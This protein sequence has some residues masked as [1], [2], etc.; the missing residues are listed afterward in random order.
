MANKIVIFTPMYNNIYSGVGTYARALVEGLKERNYDISVV[1]PDC[2][3]DSPSFIKLKNNKMDPSPNKWISNSM[4]YNSFLKNPPFKI[5]IAH[6]VNAQELLFVKKLK[7]IKFVATVHDSYSFDLKYKKL[8]KENF[9]DWRSRYIYYNLLFKLERFAFKKADMII[10]NT[11]FVKERL[12]DFY[13]IDRD[14]VLTIYVS[15][16]IR[17]LSN[18]IKSLSPPFV[19]S[20]IGGNF[21]R[22][23]L[24]NLI[25]A[26]KILKERGTDIKIKVAGKDKNQKIIERWI[27][28][29]GFNNIVDFLGH[30]KPDKVKELLLH[31]HIFAMPS[32]NEAFGLVYLEAMAYG[33]PV[34][35]TKN[36]GSKE[37]IKDGENGFLCN[38]FDPFDIAKKIELLL[39]EITREAIIEKGFETVKR[40]LNYDAVAKTIR[41]YE[42]LV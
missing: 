12:I 39:D 17:N 23:G 14:K 22:K 11:D 16:L 29:N 38:P 40:F 35:G 20:F 37:L 26:V 3:Y 28:K 10:A 15:A 31:S 6:F 8:L 33:V 32:I 36:G 18:N 19:V 34:I 13:N 2:D 7:N 24:L 21:Q 1:S 42:N 30:L 41:L 25:K 27:S 5:D 9:L 4:S